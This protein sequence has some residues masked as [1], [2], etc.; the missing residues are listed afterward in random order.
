[1]PFLLICFLISPFRPSHTYDIIARSRDT[2]IA[3]KQ[4][5]LGQRSRH[6]YRSWQ[7]TS[8]RGESGF[9]SSVKTNVLLQM[10]PCRLLNMTHDRQFSTNFSHLIQILTQSSRKYT[11]QQSP[12]MFRDKFQQESKLKSVAKHS[13]LETG[14]RDSS[15]T[16]YTK[17]RAPFWFLFLLQSATS[18]DL[19]RIDQDIINCGLWCCLLTIAVSADRVCLLNSWIPNKS[20]TIRTWALFMNLRDVNMGVVGIRPPQLA[21]PLLATCT[22][23]RL[24]DHDTW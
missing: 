23:S 11:F 21:S 22:W 5:A 19:E 15:T 8:L 6:V 4:R 14:G 17:D 9:L 16:C 3:A 13:F 10:S 24:D 18:V 12:W 2:A 7:L 20:R 1:M